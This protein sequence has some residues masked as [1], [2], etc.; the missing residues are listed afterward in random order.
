[1]QTSLL[2]EGYIELALTPKTIDLNIGEQM[3]F[4][5]AIRERLRHLDCI[6]VTSVSL[7]VDPAAA[8][9]NMPTIIEFGSHISFTGEEA[10][11]VSGKG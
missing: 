1:M 10:H 7:I 3:V 2:V 5:P 9:H 11:M 8:Y 4:P 6:P